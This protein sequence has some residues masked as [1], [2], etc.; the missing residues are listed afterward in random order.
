VL[1]G[2]LIVFVFGYSINK[3]FIGNNDFLIK[4]DK[5][6]EGK[7]PS[8]YIVKVIYIEEPHLYSLY[9]D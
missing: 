9:S 7:K 3:D 4:K 5:W 6:I 8:A 2:L 1:L